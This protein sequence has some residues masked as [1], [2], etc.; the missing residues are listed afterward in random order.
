MNS[1]QQKNEYK[2]VTRVHN[3]L[4]L[5][6]EACYVFFKESIRISDLN[7]SIKLILLL[8]KSYFLCIETEA[9]KMDD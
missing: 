9:V 6:N 1:K 8:L 4:L 2:F 3:F 7:E 5:N